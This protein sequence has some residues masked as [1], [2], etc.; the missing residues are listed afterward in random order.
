MSFPWDA[1]AE[2]T[3]ADAAWD[4]FEASTASDPLG[5]PAFLRRD[6]D[7]RA[8]FMK[9]VVPAAPPPAPFMD[10]VVTPPQPPAC[11]EPPRMPWSTDFNKPTGISDDETKT[12]NRCSCDADHVCVC[13][14]DDESC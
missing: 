9:V 12:L 5:I 8:P 11:T 6:K 1:P 14:D 10:A 2:P 4:A 7:N 13:Y 3:H